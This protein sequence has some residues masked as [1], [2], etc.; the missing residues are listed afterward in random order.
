[1]AQIKAGN[2]MDYINPWIRGSLCVKTGGHCG[3]VGLYKATF[4][5]YKKHV[6]MASEKWELNC[7]K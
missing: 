6:D 3:Y 2:H 5:L 4:F 7:L 1:M